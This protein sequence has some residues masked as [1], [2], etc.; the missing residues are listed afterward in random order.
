MFRMTNSAQPDVNLYFCIT[1][2]TFY[3]SMY[4]QLNSEF[5]NLFFNYLKGPV[6][7]YSRGEVSSNK[8]IPDLLC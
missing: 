2:V 7:K 8:V 3:V 6:V 4:A 5:R 1:Q